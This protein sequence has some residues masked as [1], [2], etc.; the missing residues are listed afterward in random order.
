MRAPL[1]LLFLLPT[2]TVTIVT[3]ALTGDARAAADDDLP[4][5]RLTVTYAPGTEL[6]CPDA[7]TIENA[8]AMRLGY[9]PF[10]DAAPRHLQASV[11]QKDGAL[12]GEV[13]LTD[14]AGTL[15][16]ERTLEG[17]GK[18]CMELSRALELAISIAI[19]PRAVLRP[20]PTIAPALLPGEEG[21]PPP[22]RENGRQMPV[23]TT[24]PPPGTVTVSPVEVVRVWNTDLPLLEGP[25]PP[26]DYAA[27]LMDLGAERARAEAP[28]P[29]VVV[30][31]APP[32]PSLASVA[33]GG[34][35]ARFVLS[36]GTGL[37]IGTTPTPSVMNSVGVGV[38]FRYGGFHLEYQRNLPAVGGITGDDDDQ[39]WADFRVVTASVCGTY[40][41]FF[42]CTGPSAGMHLFG[43]VFG[44]V[45]WVNNVILAAPENA[46]P[47]FG[48]QA[49]IG[50]DL[51]ILWFVDGWADR[52]RLRL[53]GDVNGALL[54]WHLRRPPH[55]DGG[56]AGES[57]WVVPPVG[58]TAGAG[59]V[60]GFP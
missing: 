57:L 5:V 14:D 40:D 33:S 13:R 34:P 2:T 56:A 15:L 26:P 60:V 25:P 53:H 30:D 48:G 37:T 10:D 9:V 24:R 45:Y 36:L 17:A 19:D 1:L 4:S 59:L 38:A 21:P 44:A 20:A 49:R 6:I 18:D 3:F 29:P 23:D 39:V 35:I 55:T 43:A 51:P 54:S 11:S 46:R 31:E 42:A 32:H 27:R 7:E 12:K 58:F 50:V 22:P 28:P 47:Q 8:V 16:G 52:V 41:W